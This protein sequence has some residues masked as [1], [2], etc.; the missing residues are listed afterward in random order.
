MEYPKKLPQFLETFHSSGFPYL[1]NSTTNSKAQVLSAA[2]SLD[3]CDD[4]FRKDLD[5]SFS[6]KTTQTVAAIWGK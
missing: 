4:T 1:V 3:R 2:L 5:F 6:I